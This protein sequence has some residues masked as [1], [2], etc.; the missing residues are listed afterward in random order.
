MFTL[1]LLPPLVF[2]KYLYI[3]NSLRSFLLIRAFWNYK[4]F[5][6]LII[7]GDMLLSAYEVN[8]FP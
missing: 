4:V 6:W 7:D 3:P 5:F 1:P 2:I 8:Y